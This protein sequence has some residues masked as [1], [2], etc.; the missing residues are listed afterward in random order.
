MGSQFNVH[1]TAQLWEKPF[2]IN[3]S[4]NFTIQYK[5]KEWVRNQKVKISKRR[6][7]KL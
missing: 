2:V 4:K 5:G 7:Q 6:K 3:C 1:G